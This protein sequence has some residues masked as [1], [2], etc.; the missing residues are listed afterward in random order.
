MADYSEKIILIVDDQAFLRNS[1][2]KELVRLG[3]NEG[4]ILHANNGREGLEFLNSG[5]EGEGNMIDLVLS[6]WNMP[7]MSGLDFLKRVRTSNKS[8]QKIPFALVTT[9][10]EKDKI[11]EALNFKVSGYLLKPIDPEKLKE[12][13]L[14]VF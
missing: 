12:L 5:N 7:I 3:A 10:S 4:R 13:L 9:V 2:V 14:T 11:I 1:L 8:Y 6:D